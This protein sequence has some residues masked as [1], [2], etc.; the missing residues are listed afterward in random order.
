MKKL[1]LGS[2][3]DDQTYS[4]WLI[5]PSNVGFSVSELD[6]VEGYKI[7]LRKIN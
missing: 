1:W 3:D 5:F 6:N 4:N 7:C 2:Y